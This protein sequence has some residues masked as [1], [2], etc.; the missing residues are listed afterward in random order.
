VIPLVILSTGIIPKSLS[1][2]LK[3]QPASEYV[4]TNAKICNSWNM[5]NCEKLLKLQIRPPRLFLLITCPRIGE[6]FQAEAEKLDDDDDDD[7]DNNNN[8]HFVE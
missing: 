5:F 7:N 1:Q 2:S 8:K 3:R 4:Q 6:C